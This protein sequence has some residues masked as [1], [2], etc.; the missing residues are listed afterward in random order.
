MFTGGGSVAPL[1]ARERDIARFAAA[2]ASNREIAT[3]LELSIRTVE[4]HL[5]RAYEKLGVT[6]RAELSTALSSDYS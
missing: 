6:S 1:T 4:N 3:R 2:G 5:Q